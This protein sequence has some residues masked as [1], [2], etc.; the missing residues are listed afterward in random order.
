M[1]ESIN[2]VDWIVIVWILTTNSDLNRKDRIV[3]INW[4]I[5][6]YI[7]INYLSLINIQVTVN[8]IIEMSGKPANS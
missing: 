6:Y 3:K 4:L 7:Y 1:Y 8:N 5:C 2:Q